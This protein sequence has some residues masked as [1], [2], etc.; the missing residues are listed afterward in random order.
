LKP[1]RL[2]FPILNKADPAR[3]FSI[4]ACTQVALL[5]PVK[6]V[7]E[8]KRRARLAHRAKQSVRIIGEEYADDEIR[9][10]H[11][12]PAFDSTAPGLID[13]YISGRQNQRAPNAKEYDLSPTPRH[14]VTAQSCAMFL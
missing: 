2:E 12:L 9:L 3:N 11:V 10:S 14:G 7:V 8:V 13:V 1:G 5:R 6:L 4:N